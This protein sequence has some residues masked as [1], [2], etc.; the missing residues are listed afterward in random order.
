MQNANWEAG[1][2]MTKSDFLNI[3]RQ[4]LAGEVSDSVVNDNINFYSNYIDDEMRLGKSEEEVLRVLGEPR[5]IARTIIDTNTSSYG[6]NA[7]YHYSNENSDYQSEDGY[8]SQDNKHIRVFN[9]NSWYGKLLILFIIL[10]ILFI[11]GSVL[12]FLLPLVMPILIIWFLV[13]IFTGRR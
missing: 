3:L 7:T 1:I 2:K 8:N 10:F 4:T 5:L 12:S 11:V 6:Q 13:S 9:L